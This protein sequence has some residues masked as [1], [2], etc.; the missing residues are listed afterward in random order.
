MKTFGFIISMV[1]LCG[2]LQAEDFLAGGVFVKNTIGE[3]DLYLVGVSQTIT[4]KIVV[5][6]TYTAG[7]SMLEI[8]TKSNEI[9]DLQL[10]SGTQVRV[11]PSS[12][13]RV[14]AFN[15][16]VQNVDNEPELVKYS[17]YLLNMALMDGEAQFI[18]YSYNSPNTMCIL[19]TP[20]A[21]LELNGAKCLIKAN[22][23]YVICYVVE[24]KV[25]ILHPKTNKKEEIKQGQMGFVVPFPGEQSVMITSKATEPGELLKQINAIKE[26]ESSRDSVM[27]VVIDKKVV[28]VKVK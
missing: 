24:G 21:N 14:D 8:I 1:L 3:V 10:S 2:I 13:F 17:D 27:F 22:Q 23:K 16:M 18:N 7:D 25:N 15:Q 6:R 12:E 19:Q 9:V 4:N 26:V 11:S 28:G 20:L 5:G